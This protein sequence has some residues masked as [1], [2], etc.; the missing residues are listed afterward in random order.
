[1][2]PQKIQALFDFINYL[3][4]RKT[5]L[6]ET[7]IPLCN[8]IMI[9]DRQR[10]ALNPRNNYKDKLKFDVLDKEIKEKYQPIQE[11]IYIPVT[12]KLLELGIWSG[13]RAHASIWNNNISA[14]GDFKDNFEPVDIDIVIH[15]KRKYLDFRSETNS[16]FLCLQLTLSSLDEIFKNLFDFFKDSSDNEFESF[17]TK[18]LEA[19]SWR[20][21]AAKLVDSHGK[22]VRFSLPVDSLFDYHNVK[23]LQPPQPTLH[24]Q[25]HYNMGDNIQVSDI[26]NNSGPVLIGKN[27]SI[28]ASFNQQ[29][30]LAGKIEELITLIRQDQQVEDQ[31]KQWLI[32][33]LE[34]VREELL[35]QTTDKSKISKWLTT[36]KGV[37]KNVTFSHDVKE[38]ADWIYKALHSLI[39]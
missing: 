39:N 8:T 19:T 16:N 33:N 7:Y 36:A 29:T 38:A 37:L 20:D 32:T 15:H 18:T 21:V 5:E 11:Y 4:S 28:T 3:D 30:E 27:N 6:V 9:L 35:E 23:H 2:I 31:Q 25:N 24:I 12:N 1:M 26:N 22:K 13:D 10:S 34:K 17:E 14:I